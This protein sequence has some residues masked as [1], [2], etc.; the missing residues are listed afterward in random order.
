M[1]I[2]FFNFLEEKNQRLEKRHFFNEA[3][4][5]GKEAPQS[6]MQFDE[7]S[8]K[9]QAWST[10]RKRSQQDH[11]GLVSVWNVEWISIKKTFT[12]ITLYPFWPGNFI[13]SCHHI[14]R[15]SVEPSF[16]EGCVYQAGI[17]V[18]EL[19]EE[20]F[21]R[22]AL[23]KLWLCP[24][25]LHRCD[26]ASNPLKD[27]SSWLQKV[28]LDPCLQNGPAL[29]TSITKAFKDAAIPV[30]VNLAYWSKFCSGPV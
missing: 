15:V 20:H 28:K 18:D 19:K 16:E 21:E 3:K 7:I 23:L 27:V 30:A 11:T 8:C 13:G 2:Q 24:G 17:V 5:T 6:L 25:K 14:C 9:C 26:L 1:R 10:T 4:L 29:N 22:V 12:W